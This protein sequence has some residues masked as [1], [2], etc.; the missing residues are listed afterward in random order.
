[1]GIFDADLLPVSSEYIRE[2]PVFSFLYV[3]FP[4]LYYVSSG[5]EFAVSV[6]FPLSASEANLGAVSCPWYRVSRRDV[7]SVLDFVR[8]EFGVSSISFSTAKESVRRIARRFCILREV[9]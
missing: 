7:L 4:V 2:H 9:F 6:H 8:C 3:E 1:M 5:H